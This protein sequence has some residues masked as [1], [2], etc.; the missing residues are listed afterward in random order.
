VWTVEQ[1]G[2]ETVCPT[3]STPPAKTATRSLQWEMRCGHPSRNTDFYCMEDKPVC[4]PARCGS[5]V[6]RPNAPAWNAAVPQTHSA[7]ANTT[8]YILPNRPISNLLVFSDQAEQNTV[9]KGQGSKSGNA[10]RPAMVSGKVRLNPTSLLLSR[11]P[12]LGAEG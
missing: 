10:G 6:H 1:F 12:L 9:S 8:Q 2:G 11:P 7:L 5:S 3:R 4:S